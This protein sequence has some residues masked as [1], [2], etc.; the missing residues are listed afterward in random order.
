MKLAEREGARSAVS[1]RTPV[2]ASAEIS[3]RAPNFR[4]QQ[5]RL[6]R[7]STNGRPLRCAALASGLLPHRWT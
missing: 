2:G 6:D 3:E 7:R 4:R 5:R 1:R